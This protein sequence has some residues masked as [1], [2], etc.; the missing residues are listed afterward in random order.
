MRE[1][2]SDLLFFHSTRSSQELLVFPTGRAT[3]FRASFDGLKEVLHSTNV[4]Q[5]SA[6]QGLGIITSTPHTAS[7]ASTSPIQN[8]CADHTRL[9]ADISEQNGI[10]QNR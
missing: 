5:C 4:S 1:N 8:R 7:S 9:M 6:R 2:A 3:S 10:E